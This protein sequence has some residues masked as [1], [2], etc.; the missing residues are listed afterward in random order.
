[1]SILVTASKN[2]GQNAT[3]QKKIDGGLTI[4]ISQSTTMTVDVMEILTQFVEEI[5][6]APGFGCGFSIPTN[7]RDLQVVTLQGRIWGGG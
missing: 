2:R 6:R 5:R 3:A 1:M 4:V 7:D